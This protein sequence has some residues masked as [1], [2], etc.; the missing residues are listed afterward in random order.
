MT[1]NVK[2]EGNKLLQENLRKQHN[3]IEKFMNPE[4]DG[5]KFA[6]S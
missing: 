4:N 6:T 3:I 1:D 2:E 5:E